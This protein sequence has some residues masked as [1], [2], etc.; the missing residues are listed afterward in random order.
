[1]KSVL[2]PI[3]SLFLM[4]CMLSSFILL[5]NAYETDDPIIITAVHDSYSPSSF[6]DLTLIPS[7][8][9]PA[10]WSLPEKVLCQTGDTSGEY[11]PVDWLIPPFRPSSGRCRI[12]GLIRLPEGYQFAEPYM[13]IILYTVMLTDEEMEPEPLAS[14]EGNS[15]YSYTCKAGAMT[16]E[17]LLTALKD[18]NMGM[19]AVT[20]QGETLYLPAKSWDLS[21]VDLNT[22]GVYTIPGLP[23]LPPCFS[24]PEEES[25]IQYPV[26]HLTVEDDK[27]IN[28]S[29]PV[30]NGNQVLLNWTQ[31]ITDLEN[32]VLEYAVDNEEW[33]TVN[34][35]FD[36]SS[37][38]MTFSLNSLEKA[39]MLSQ[40]DID[41]TLSANAFQVDLYTPVNAVY[42][43]RLRY[44]DSL[45]DILC[46]QPTSTGAFSP[47][48]LTDRF[49]VDRESVSM[50]EIEI[51][52][53]SP[54]S[55]PTPAPTAP[56]NSS[57]DPESSGDS[58]SSSSGSSGTA[59]SISDSKTVMNGA[60]V[61]ELMELY[62]NYILFEKHGIAVYIPISFLQQLNLVD[63][64]TLT[65]EILHRE[66]GFSFSLMVNQSPVDII[67][68]TRVRFPISQ[69]DGA[70]LSFLDP[71][72]IRLEDSCVEISDSLVTLTVSHTG[73]YTAVWETD[74][75][76]SSDVSSE[77]VTSPSYEPPPVTDHRLFWLIPIA[78][79]WVC[80]GG[81]GVILWKKRKRT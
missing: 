47:S 12:L 15:F 10:D 21:G 23:E 3:V 9:S 77:P 30:V 26:L 34:G 6:N 31:P 37:Q 81:I 44:Q 58:S 54:S 22:P 14:I 69:A 63:T 50:P 5:A 66:N 2:K 43:F 1:M 41:C 4:L 59:E 76:S 68:G 52:S 71:S 29:K 56:P 33:Q 75:S 28:F 62:H 35:F 46:I 7:D 55:S 38:T 79:L 32:Y 65:V 17:E 45:T 57:S 20:K 25:A 78:A 36:P 61:Q 24:L 13:A 40:P 27:P 51:P 73:S 39:R 53:S 64:D 8:L 67:P 19:Y 16:E 70:V 42:F 72:G 74:A 60:R 11:F 48:V 49:T 80:A 18:A